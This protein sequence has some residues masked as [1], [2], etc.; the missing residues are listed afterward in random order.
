MSRLVAMEFDE[1]GCS[2]VLAKEVDALC[3]YVDIR[4]LVL[5]P[6]TDLLGPE[7][8]TFVTALERERGLIRGNR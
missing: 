8:S 6:G 5:G 2:V 7:E 3:L 1:V 4:S